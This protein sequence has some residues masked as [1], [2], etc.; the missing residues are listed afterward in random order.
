MS[1]NSCVW[2]CERNLSYILIIIWTQDVIYNIKTGFDAEFEALHK[3]KMQEVVNVR[4]RNKDIRQIMAKL[5]MQGELWEPS[6]T[7]GEQ[8]ERLFTVDDSE[9][10]NLLK[11]ERNK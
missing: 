3:Q 10:T 6:L 4:E 8:P 9:V 7:D 2:S 5:D 11:Y 1:E